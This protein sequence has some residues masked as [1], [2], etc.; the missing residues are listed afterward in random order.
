MIKNIK[1]KGTFKNLMFI[2]STIVGVM[3]AFVMVYIAWQ[4]NPQC[5]FYCKDEIFYS[6]ILILWFSW[7]VIGF[8]VV[9]L[10]LLTYRIFHR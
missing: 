4:H 9:L 1:F 8:L 6:R 10:I 7:F 2:L 3:L 5:E